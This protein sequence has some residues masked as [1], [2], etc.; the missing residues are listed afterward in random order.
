MLHQLRYWMKYKPYDEPQPIW[1]LLVHGAVEKA[2]AFDE[3]R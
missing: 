2:L 3:V 1:L